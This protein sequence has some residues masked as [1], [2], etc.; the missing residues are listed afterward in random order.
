MSIRFYANAPATALASSCSNSQLTI[1]VNS[2]TGYPI[3]YPFTVIVDRGTATEE[4]MSVTGAAGAVFTVTRAIDSTTAFSHSI[5]AVVEHG[6][7]AQDIREP[8]AHIN[9]NT[10][11]HGVAGS[12][13]GTTDVQVVTNKDL[14]AGTNSFPS[15]LATLTGAQALTNKTIGATNTI[16]GFTASRFM[17]ADGTGRLASGTKVVPAGVVVGTTDT[18]ALTNKDLTAGTNTFPTSLATLTGVQTLTN[19]TL[20]SP[21]LN[22]PTVTSPTITTPSIGGTAITRIQFG[23]DPGNAVGAPFVQF[24]GS[25]TFPAAFASTPVVMLTESGPAGAAV[26]WSVTAVSTTGFSWIARWVDGVN[27]GSSGGVNWLAIV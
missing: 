3:Q 1:T 18:Q 27:H 8:N 12:V 13:V 15:A 17:E 26:S 11:V 6:I 9:A 24:T 22:T 21:T 25:V 19:K 16:N 14:T 10:G 4:A 7:T 20:T 5:G 23:T 2:A